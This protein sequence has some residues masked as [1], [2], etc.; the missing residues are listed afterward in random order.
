M[1]DNCKSSLPKIEECK[2][3]TISVVQG[4]FIAR[5]QILNVALIANELVE[6]YRDAEKKREE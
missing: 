1:Q 6:D 3:K 2:A 4:T 5:R